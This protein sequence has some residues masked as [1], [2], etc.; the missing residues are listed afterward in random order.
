MQVINRLAGA[1]GCV[2]ALVVAFASPALSQANFYEGKTIRIVC[3]LGT[4]GGYDSYA[5]L[6]SRHLGK[7]IPGN[8]TIVVQNMPGAGGIVAANHIYNVAPKDGTS[9]GA[10]HANIAL[11]QVTDTANLEYDV[12]KII[13]V[14]RQVSGGLDIH[15]TWHTTGVKSFDDLLKR[16]VVFG[17]GGP[18][19]S[20]IVEANA[21]N[22]L[23]GG[24]LKILGGY[25]GTAETTLALERGEIDMASKNWEL[26]RVQH[27]DW[28]KEKKINL[29]VQFSVQ[30][31]PELP[32]LPTILEVSKDEKTKQVWRLV[33]SPVQIGYALSMAPGV[34][35]DRV[36]TIRKAFDAMLNDAEFKA[37]AEKAKLDLEPASGEQLEQSVQAMFKADAAA[38]SEVK[39]LLAQ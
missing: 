20:S 31:H 36:A 21:I 25:K 1:A 18:T 10:L 19:S 24:K 2:A 7:H 8:P 28:L 4:G 9:I 22:K 17:G 32:D 38:V 6:A 23:M 15:H 27:T 16:E 29:I 13:W 37:D 12:R 5:R 35:A 11:A 30:R 34:P 33:L 14:G 3:A 39:A 26:I